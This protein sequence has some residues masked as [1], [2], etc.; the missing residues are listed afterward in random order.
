MYRHLDRYGI[1]KWP[2]KNFFSRDEH[3]I[4]IRN[5]IR[6]Q[7]SLHLARLQI[8]SYDNAIL[9]SAKSWKHSYGWVDRAV[10][11]LA[12]DCM[13][14]IMIC[15]DPL[16]VVFYSYTLTL[17]CSELRDQPVYCKCRGLQVVKREEHYRPVS[18]KSGP[19]CLRRVSGLLL[20]KF[21][22]LGGR[23]LEVVG[24]TSRFECNTIQLGTVSKAL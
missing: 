11:G 21:W 18:P 20:G 22:C 13:Q 12:I 4:D 23:L 7:V 9:L 17:R 2:K 1:V 8:Q 15:V 14:F 5:P 24:R 10:A 19:G 6:T 16:E 3:K